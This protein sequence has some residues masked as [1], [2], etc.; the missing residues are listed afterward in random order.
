MA[1]CRIW[2]IV[3]QN[4]CRGEKRF[5]PLHVKCIIIVLTVQIKVWFITIFLEVEDTLKNGH[6]SLK[7]TILF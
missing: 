4:K 3:E 2:L 6:K 5:G 7:L 1:H